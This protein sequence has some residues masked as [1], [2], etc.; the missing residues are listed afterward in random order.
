MAAVSSIFDYFSPQ[1]LAT[2]CSEE[3]ELAA[4]QI[5]ANIATKNTNNGR[6]VNSLGLPEETTGE[7]AASIQTL[8]EHAADGFSVTLAGRKGIWGLDKGQSP[9]QVQFQF[10][11]FW[12]CVE[13]MKKW[14]HAKE[15][16]YG[17]A[18][19]SINAYSVASNIWQK[20]TI[21]YREG[22]GQEI[23]RDPLDPAMQ[24]IS[25]RISEELNTSI[26]QLM[27]MTVE[28]ENIEI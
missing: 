28:N 1:R 7:S 9:A 26:Y 18:P 11:N 27:D 12:D 21:L 20:G 2:I 16:R 24:R 10:S 3:F 19:R 6:A 22:G 4:Q 25:E 23:L 13:T 5:R 8:F 17:L 15:A 14:S